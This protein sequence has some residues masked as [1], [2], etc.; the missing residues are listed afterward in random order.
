MGYQIRAKRKG[1]DTVTRIFFDAR[2]IDHPGIGRYIR[3][4]LPHMSEEMSVELFLLGDRAKIKKF[5]GIEKNIIDFEYPIYSLQ[6]Q[7]GFI[8]L[9]RT[10]GND[11]LHI[12]HYNI[13]IFAKF[14]LVTTVHDL[15]HIIYP[16][17]ASGRLAPL[18][19]NFMIRKI[20]KSARAVICV[21]EATK[22]EIEK[23]MPGA[24]PP[25]VIYEGVD[26][27]FTMIADSVYLNKIKKKYNL[28][29]KYI[30][31]VGSIRRHKNIKALLDSFVR[32]KERVPEARLI[33][34]GRR[35]Q[36]IDID[37]DGVTY[38]GE[39]ESDRELAAIY[40]LASC[41]FNLS[42]YEGFGLTILEAQACGLPV[43]CSDIPAHREIGRDGILAVN[44]SYIDRIYENMYNILF[45]NDLRKGLILKGHEN[46]KRFNW[47]VTARQTLELYRKI[48][49]E[50]SDSSRL[51]SGDAGRRK[52]PQRFLQDIPPGRTLYADP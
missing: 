22:N 20:M 47:A 30:L 41:L 28:P 46:V 32:F 36:D 25:H 48:G 49:D 34:V 19:M 42:L 33:L 11:I 15:I 43:L 14:N 9:K 35:G 18:Y 12:P 52:D 29:D 26:R 16:E 40:N 17:G 51:A 31:Y 24:H 2:M 6:E 13:P 27:I 4:L 3:C 44:P 45:N 10:V 21:S 1:R 50:G 8:K 23:R 37:R 39:V 5:L 7:A 38:I